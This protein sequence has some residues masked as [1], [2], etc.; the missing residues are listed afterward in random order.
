MINVI[1]VPLGSVDELK[2][3]ESSAAHGIGGLFRNTNWY[4][5]SIE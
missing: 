1:K 5:L 2:S 4:G 3:L